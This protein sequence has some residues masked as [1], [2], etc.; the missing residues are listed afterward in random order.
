MRIVRRF[1]LLSLSG[2]K[3]PVPDGHAVDVD[4]DALCRFFVMFDDG[5]DSRGF[6]GTRSS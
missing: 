2:S 1:N 4:G 3:I 5:V 6:S